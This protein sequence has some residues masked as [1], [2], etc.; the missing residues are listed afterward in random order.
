MVVDITGTGFSPI[1]PVN[2]SVGNQMFAPTVYSDSNGDLQANG[3]VPDLPDG[4]AYVVAYDVS[5]VTCQAPIYVYSE[6]NNGTTAPSPTPSS[7]YPTVPIPTPSVPEFTVKYVNSSY[8][9][10][11][12]YS[13]DPYTGQNVTHP[14]YYV[15]NESIV[16]TIK[17]Q[18]FVSF[19]DTVN[20]EPWNIS[21]FYNIEMKGHYAENW[22]DQYPEDPWYPWYPAN[23]NS[24]YTIISNTYGN[25]SILGDIP[26]GAQVD[27]QV[28]ALIGYI[29]RD[30]SHGFFDA[31]YVFNGQTSG[32]SNTQTITIGSTSTS[33][34]P[35]STQAVSEFPTWIILPLF[36][37]IILTSAHAMAKKGKEK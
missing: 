11:T 16:V 12:S 1:Q 7:S 34:T 3:N 30:F 37:V 32:W 10:P 29:D 36:A 5:G 25:Y 22:T 28:E 4:T 26:S 24:N 15:D 9:V 14:S 8:E 2:F 17:N 21:L 13:T 19:M 31:P 6:P 27:F 35:N 18:P 20:G 23:S 33:P